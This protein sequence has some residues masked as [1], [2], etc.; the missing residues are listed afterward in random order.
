MLRYLPS[1]DTLISAPHVTVA[2][3]GGG[4]GGDGVGCN[5]GIGGV[6]VDIGG[7]VVVVGGCCWCWC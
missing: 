2:E 7:V 5:G 1:S 4:V 6:G 3:V